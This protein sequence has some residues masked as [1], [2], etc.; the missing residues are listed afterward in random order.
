MASPTLRESGIVTLPGGVSPVLRSEPAKALMRLVER[1]ASSPA[2]VLIQGETGSGKELIARALHHL[3]SRS[4]KPWV[5]INCAALPEHL[6]ESELFGHEKGA[7]SG[8]DSLKIGLFELAHGGTLFL[9]EIGELDLRVQGKLLRI[10]DDAPYF[11]LGGTKKVP[12]D[13][14]VIA[15]TNRD[16]KAASESGKFRSDLYFRLSQVQLFVPPLRER[17]DDIEEIAAQV[18]HKCSPDTTLSASALQVLCKYS[19]PGNI[20]ELKN[21]L[22]STAV[23]LDPASRIIRAEDLPNMLSIRSGGAA[24][25]E[26]PSGDLDSMERVMIERALKDNG[27]QQAAA[28]DALGISRRTL[29]RKIKAY[30]LESATGRSGNLGTLNLEQYRYFRAALDRPV[31]VRTSRSDEVTV[32]SVN[33]SSSGLGV[34]GMEESQRFGGIVE[35]E[36]SFSDAAPKINLKGKVTWADSQGN[37][38]I[39]FLSVPRNAQ[40]LIDD[41]IAKKRSEEGWARTV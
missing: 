2:A 32:E 11:R 14:R 10:L 8:A 13:V 40:Q 23:M 18:L 31:M 28:A 15:A 12:V 21:V 34:R 41:W 30:Q 36:F 6:V 5:D 22:T 39:R 37:A 33:L 1:V 35:L 3:S 25:E 38:G 16:L 29:T 20:R 19:W 9:D 17:V 27:G 4:H 7:F 26:V 24:D